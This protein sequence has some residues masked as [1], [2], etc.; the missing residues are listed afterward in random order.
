MSSQIDDYQLADRVDELIDDLLEIDMD[1]IRLT[2]D[3]LQLEEVDETQLLRV[4]AETFIINEEVD[5]SQV[6]QG[7]EIIVGEAPDLEL[8]L[9][10]TVDESGQKL[11]I[12]ATDPPAN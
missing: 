10:Y 1:E 4:L 9:L 12:I 8:Y 5:R 3:Q 2:P 6:H 11:L 7:D